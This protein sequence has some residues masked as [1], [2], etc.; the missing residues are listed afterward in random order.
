MARH[1]EIE[2]N[3]EIYFQS[4]QRSSKESEGSFNVN[5]HLSA[6]S[7][8]NENKMHFHRNL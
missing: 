2:R 8:F 5:S 6:N 4:F 3:F 1:F 7:K